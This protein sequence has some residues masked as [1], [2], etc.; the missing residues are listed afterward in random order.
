MAL[1]K[2]VNGHCA[3][4]NRY[5]SLLRIATGGNL[6]TLDIAQEVL[7]ERTEKVAKSEE[8]RLIVVQ[9]AGEKHP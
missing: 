6:C 4:R 5:F 8:K 9:P 7:Q 2:S 1:E 3:W